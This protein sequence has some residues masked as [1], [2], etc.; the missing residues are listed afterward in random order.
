MKIIEKT[1]IAT[2]ADI[3]QLVNTF[4]EKVKADADIG[5]FFTAVMHVDWD[6]HLPKM[7]DFWE[8]LLFYTGN[9]T[10]NPML[11]HRKVNAHAPISAAHF[12][13]WLTLFNA[14]VDELFEGERADLVKARALNIA[15][16]MQ[17]K[18]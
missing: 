2:R 16:V 11:V 5:Y 13:Q 1:D 7:Y 6:V 10:G 12:G 4:Y 8:N 17:L 3:E 15:T 18:I 14:T 9:Y